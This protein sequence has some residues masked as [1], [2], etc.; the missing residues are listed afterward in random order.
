MTSTRLRSL[1]G[2]PCR[3]IDVHACVSVSQFQ[4]LTNAP[5]L[6]STVFVS[7]IFETLLLSHQHRNR[8]IETLVVALHLQECLRIRPLAELVLKVAALINED[9]AIIGEDDPR[10]FEWTR[11]G[12]FEVDAGPS[13]TTALTRTFL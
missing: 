3:K 5:S 2:R 12:T 9:L 10:P 13:E 7:A 4:N 11:R 1:V 6:G 8:G